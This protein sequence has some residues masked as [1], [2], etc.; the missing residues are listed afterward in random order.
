MNK[1][2][3]QHMSRMSDTPPKSRDLDHLMEQ[4]STELDFLSAYGG[5]SSDGDGSAIFA[6]LRRF[7]KAGGVSFTLN[8]KETTLSFAFGKAAV[9]DN[10]CAISFKGKNL[11]LVVSDVQQAGFTQGTLT[12]QRTS[13]KV[14]M[15]EWG[16]EQRRFIERLVEYLNHDE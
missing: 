12:K 8:K 9:K 5:S 2:T 13:C 1:H 15:A 4:N 10:G 14:T 3:L 7:L 6:A 16:L 11:P